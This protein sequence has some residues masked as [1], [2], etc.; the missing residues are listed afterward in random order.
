VNEQLSADKLDDLV[1]LVKKSFPDIHCL[2]CGYSNFHILPA[3]QQTFMLGEPAQ[4][5]R[6]LPVV[7]LACTRC[8]HIE[9]HLSEKLRESPIPLEVD[10][11]AE[12]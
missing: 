9:Q 8:G 5:P 2:R 10:K 11:S 1:G 3:T 4:A 12:L 6:L 7:T